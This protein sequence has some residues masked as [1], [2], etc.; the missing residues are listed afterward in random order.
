MTTTPLDQIKVLGYVRVST[1]EQHD[2]G[3]GLDAQRKSITD[4]CERRGWELV[5][6]MG[7]DAG[8]SAKEIDRPGLNAVRDAMDAGKADVLMVS[9]LDRL[10]RNTWQGLKFIEEAGRKGKRRNGKRKRAPWSVVTAEMDID[11]T[12][13]AGMMHL[14][15]HLGFT[16]YERKLIGERTRDGM[17]AKRAAGTLKG[18]IGRPAALPADVAARIRADRASG[19]SYGKIAATL[20]AEKIATAHGGAAWYPATVKRVC[21][22][23]AYA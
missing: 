6:I 21:E 20:N 3:G 22:S 18:T 11:T 15:M 14:T 1:D 19:L 5:D 2:N 7:E 8:A 10:S 16:Q 9:K 17:A 23:E 13:A 12:T 4:L